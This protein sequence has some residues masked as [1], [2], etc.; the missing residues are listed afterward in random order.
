MKVSFFGGRLVAAAL[1]A[2]SIPA[3]ATPLTEQ[4]VDKLRVAFRWDRFEEIA[5]DQSMK[6]LP[7]GVSVDQRACVRSRI[8][9]AY[10]AKVRESIR[11]AIPDQET[12]LAWME[13]AATP[14]GVAFFGRTGLEESE[15]SDFHSST[16]GVSA[17]TELSEVEGDDLRRFAE[18]P[19]GSSGPPLLLMMDGAEMQR[20]ST[21]ISDE[22]FSSKKNRSPDE[23]RSAN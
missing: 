9:K 2:L 19:A 14:G 23:S 7:A 16:V 17:A 1:L 13:F 15:T 4:D 22:C 21:L 12:G 11:A 20:L 8:T 10:N 6:Q 5:V 18:T 3:K